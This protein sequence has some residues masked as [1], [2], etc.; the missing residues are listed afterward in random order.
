MSTFPNYSCPLQIQARKKSGITYYS[1]KIYKQRNQT[2][3]LCIWRTILSDTKILS[4]NYHVSGKQSKAVHGFVLRAFNLTFFLVM[5]SW[6]NQKQSRIYFVFVSL[7]ELQLNSFPKLMIFMC[8]KVR[9][10]ELVQSTSLI[11]FSLPKQS[12]KAYII[13]GNG[14]IARKK[15]S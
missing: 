3:P 14:I 11:L 9:L 2:P 12:L 8:K 6:N 15:K 1:Y 4:L 5:Y 10:Q 7:S 13:T